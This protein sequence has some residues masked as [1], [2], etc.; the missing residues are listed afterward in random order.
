MKQKTHQTFDRGCGAE[1]SLAYS[2]IPFSWPNMAT[3]MQ[4][5]FFN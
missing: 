2:L 1:P 3:L 5:I 4:L